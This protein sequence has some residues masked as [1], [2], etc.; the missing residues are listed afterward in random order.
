MELG[1]ILEGPHQILQLSPEPVTAGEKQTSLLQICRSGFLSLTAK[2][3]PKGHSKFSICLSRSMFRPC[4]LQGPRRRIC[5]DWNNTGS[6]ALQLLLGLTPKPT[7]Q[8]GSTP[9]AAQTGKKPLFQLQRSHSLH[10]S[11]RTP[12][13]SSGGGG[14]TKPRQPKTTQY[15]DT[16]KGSRAAGRGVGGRGGELW[17]DGRPRRVPGP[18]E[19]A[20]R[21]APGKRP[22]PLARTL[23]RCGPRPSP[24]CKPEEQGVE[25]RRRRH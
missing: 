13:N 24:R 4:L 3:V 15:V 22:S 6:L 11:A 12:A 19:G 23:A 21:G 14:C 10:C 18:G 9:G 1:D 5:L 2:L 7:T 20:A 25:R 16:S 8:K 17:G